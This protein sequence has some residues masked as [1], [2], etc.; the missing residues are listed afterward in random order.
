MKKGIIIIL[1]AINFFT[2]YSQTS[3]VGD[4]ILLIE[5]EKQAN[6]M[7]NTFIRGDY[8]A[9]AKYN[10]PK[11]LKLMGGENQMIATLTK[12]INDTRNKGVVFTGI[13]FDNPTKIIKNKN[14]LQCTIQQHLIA[15]VSNGKMIS[16]STL[17]AISLN[18][19]KN[20]YFVD[21]SNK[22]MKILKSV[23]PSISNEI[24][25]PKQGQPQFIKG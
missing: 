9:F 8:H 12:S 24:V 19:G 1:I 14:E 21:T 22:D 16:A 4:K 11:I 5:M 6:Q 15:N 18:S 13:K 25:I 3:N 17:I 20:W 10:H 23:L 2:S 7:G